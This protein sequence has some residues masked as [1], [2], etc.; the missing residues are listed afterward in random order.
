VKPPFDPQPEL[1]GDTLQLRPLKQED[2]ESLFVVASA[3]VIWKGH[4]VNDRYE[5]AVFMPYAQSLLK[6]GTTL[7]VLD[8]QENRIIGCSRY[9]AAPDAPNSISI[10]FTFLH[11]A[12][13]GGE[14]NFELKRLMLQHAFQH[15]PEVWFH[16]AP[17]NLRSQKATAKLGA[18]HIR[19]A[20]LDLSGSATLW[21]CFR[22][23]R[24]AWE[25]TCHDRAATT[26]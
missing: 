11:H 2:L 3:P 26:R 25:K 4:P 16:I 20:V 8:G 10:G 9:Y 7:V 22:L 6:S 24:A 12:Y 23:T 1:Y 13:W 17:S 14:T 21:M 5:R 18:E 15:F 19:D